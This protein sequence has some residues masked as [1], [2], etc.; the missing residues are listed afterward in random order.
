MLLCTYE[1][2]F[3][4]SGTCG[5]WYER[6]NRKN[7]TRTLQKCSKY[8]NPCFLALSEACELQEQQI[9]FA[10]NQDERSESLPHSYPDSDAKWLLVTRRNSGVRD[11]S[12]PQPPRWSGGGDG[13]GRIGSDTVPL[14]VPGRF[15]AATQ[16]TIPPVTC[17]CGSKP[18]EVTT[19]R[20]EPRFTSLRRLR[21]PAPAAGVRLYLARHSFDEL[22]EATSHPS[23]NRSG[24]YSPTVRLD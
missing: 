23:P 21:Q 16:S 4:Q 15:L 12:A 17:M 20:R 2:P 5:C 7:R 19:N 18:E 22:H 6:G 13:A 14:K 24:V 3:R 9:N 1:G 11:T 8:K 10:P